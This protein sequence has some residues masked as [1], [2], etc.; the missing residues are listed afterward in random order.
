MDLERELSRVLHA[1]DVPL[2]PAPV[3][4]VRAGMRRRQR[5]RRVQA[6]VAALAVAGV[7]LGVMTLV[8]DR[9]PGTR[10]TP[11]PGASATAEPTAQATPTKD[12]RSVSSQGADL[13]WVAVDDGFAL[14]T[15]PCG[16]G[17]CSRLLS[18]TDGGRTWSDV[19]A[20]G[21]PHAC[22]TSCP[23]RV[24]FAD[25]L[26]GYVY[27]DGLVMTTDG[28]RTWTRQPGPDTH[29]LEA[30]DGTALRV[31]ELT[32]CPGCRF[33]V[34]RSQAGSSTWRTV[35]T[36]DDLFAAADL[37]RQGNDVAVALK[38]NPA[39]GAGDA[40][41]T[42]L[43]SSDGGTTWTTRDD[44][45]G[46]IGSND[47]EEVDATQVSWSLDGELLVLCQRR[48]YRSNGGNAQ[49]MRSTD[50]GRAFSRPTGF[51]EITDVF[52]IASGRGVLLAETHYGIDREVLLQRSTDDGQSWTEVTR[53]PL[54]Q[55]ELTGYLAFSTAQVATWVPPGGTEVR[56]STDGGL[57]W[58]SWPLR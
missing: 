42:L 49:V 54:P 51:G 40:H 52:L 50:G 28:G 13:S 7:A 30:A 9:S 43:L 17:T 58:T 31:V 12:G 41:T 25:R 48:L 10:N 36:S 4:D 3:A 38:Q 23:L 18:T 57:T 26:V 33:A 47:P 19:G 2:V 8:P 1:V 22:T 11:L 34:Q 53:A 45:C 56:R 32:G 15:A 29:G 14:T 20:P 16:S 21:L 35:H 27:G 39:G 24:R 37:V 46:G 5:V 55:G 44:P 6:A